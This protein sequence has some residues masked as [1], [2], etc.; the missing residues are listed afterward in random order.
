[1]GGRGSASGSVM[2]ALQRGVDRY[3]LGI[4]KEQLATRMY[5]AMEAAGH[6]ASILND[7]Y[8]TVNGKTYQFIKSQKEGRWIVKDYN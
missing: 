8:V 2:G 3:G 5:R 4:S 6:H 7:K 1:M